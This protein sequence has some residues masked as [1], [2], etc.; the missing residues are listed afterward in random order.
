MKKLFSNRPKLGRGVLVFIAS[1]A[2]LYLFFLGGYLFGRTG[3]ETAVL[4]IGKSIEQ[5]KPTDVDFSLFWEVW[6]KVHDE[7]S[8]S[9]DDQKMIYG[10]IS[11]S[12]A[13]LGD[14]Y[15]AFF[16]PETNNKFQEE[17]SG[18]FEG[19]GAELSIKD[20][21]LI[22]VAPLK[23]TPAE[24]AG[25]LP[26]DYI[27]S[28]DGTKTADLTV[29]QAVSLIR[30]PKGSQV[31]LVIVRGEETREFK[32]TRE[33]IILKSVEYSFEN[34]QG[35]EIAIVKINQFGDDTVD[36][37]D[38]FADECQ[39]KNCQK[40]IL[41]LR[42]NPGGYFDGAIDIASYFIEEGVV[43]KE[44]DKKGDK[45]EY[46]T[47][48]RAKL[49]GRKVVGLIN[50]GSASAAEIVAGAL[51]DHGL[52]KLV[53]EKSFGKGSVQ[54]FE[55]L[56]S[57]AAM[58]VTVAKWLTPKEREIDQQGIE[59]EIKVEMTEDDY[60]NNRDPQLAAAIREI[61]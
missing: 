3:G 30:G 16:D 54:N 52:I 14:P 18:Q 49:A 19:I 35:K 23:K 56:S 47:T 42:N 45:K 60:L 9:I 10:A 43:V 36:L 1:S 40:I 24:R 32:I 22:V 57:G 55:Q 6:N 33:T 13:A 4:P 26:N 46:R 53:G 44:V 51:A 50:L 27:V 48:K 17:I 7:Y 31:S 20:N 59:P 39:E 29:D 15:T 25:I 34:H 61:Q 8:S 37:F 2:I 5:E 12:L 21:R 38:Q 11:G 41:D 58:K 28:I